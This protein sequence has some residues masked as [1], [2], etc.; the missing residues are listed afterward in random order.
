MSDNASAYDIGRL[1]KKIDELKDQMSHEGHDHVE[2][3]LAALGVKA[4][5]SGNATI[6]IQAGFGK[7]YVVIW[8]SRPH[9]KYSD[10]VGYSVREA[11]GKAWA[12]IGR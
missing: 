12:E 9:D 8:V 10:Y 2:K 11:F 1:Q 4:G 5:G 6:T 3:E 7:F